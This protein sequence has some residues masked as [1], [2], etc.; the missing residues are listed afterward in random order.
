MFELGNGFSSC[1]Q[2][3]LMREIDAAKD[4]YALINNSLLIEDK[5]DSAGRIDSMVLAS[6]GLNNLMSQS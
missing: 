1:Y 3:L 5:K 6:S 2:F 4:V